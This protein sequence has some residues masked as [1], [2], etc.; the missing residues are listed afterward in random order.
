[1]KKCDNDYDEGERHKGRGRRAGASE[2]DRQRLARACLFVCACA[3]LHA[4]QA[5][6]SDEVTVGPQA[7]AEGDGTAPLPAGAH[8]PVRNGFAEHLKPH[9]ALARR[10]GASTDARP[11][12]PIRAP[13]DEGQV[14]EIEM[15]VGESRVFPAPGVARIAVGNGSILTA[16][17]L[18]QKEVILF[19]NGPGT[20]SLFVWNV[21]GR[22]QRV[23]VNIVPGDTSRFAR[24][25]AAFLTAIPNAKASVVGANII[26]EGDDLSDNDLRKIEELAKRYPQIVNFTNRLGWEQ[27]VLMDVKVVEFPST[28]L[29]EIGLKW[30]ATGGAAVG[31]IWAPGRRGHSGPYQIDIH[32]GE[33]NAPPITNPDGSGGGVVL[34]SGL[35]VLS[36]INMGLN[37]QLNLLAQEGKAAVLA[38]PQLSARNGA[39]ANFLAGGE[40][41][42]TVYTINGPRVQFKEYGVKLDIEPRVDHRGVIRAQINTEVSSIDQSVSTASGPALLS[43]K[44]NTEFNVRDGETIVLAGLLQRDTGSDVDKVPLLG[45]LP[46]LGP[47]FRSKR[48][49]NRETELVVFVTPT[50]VSAQS[51][52]LQDRVQRVSD[53]L[54]ER[55]GPPPH[56]TEP[57]QPGA[58]YQQ[59]NTTPAPAVAQPP[60][61]AGVDAPAAGRLPVS[62]SAPV[63]PA[64]APT[65]ADA[66]VARP[67]AAASAA[68]LPGGSALRVVVDA[69]ALRAEPH[70]RAPALLQLGIGSTVLMGGALPHADG[71]AVWRHV[72]VGSVSGWVPST[73]V[74]PARGSL[75]I[76]AAPGGAARQDQAGRLAALPSGRASAPE[77]L[78]PAP[79]DV[80]AASRYRVTL[81]RLALRVAPDINA[82]VVVHL[83]AGDVIG[84]L[85][86]PPR[87][88]WVAVQLGD[89]GE[90]KRGWVPAQW[91]EPPTLNSPLEGQR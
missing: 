86:Q 54:E 42:Y 67:P 23:K 35:N 20:S 40:I 61:T 59:P 89:G 15:F 47:L 28:V 79:R 33:G 26:V 31:G 10:T 27:M 58:Q 51:A 77:S 72:L 38:E 44:A 13:D 68:P 69:M 29:R 64:T 50:V 2:V 75:T 83:S 16:A 70:S 63:Q 57:L 56:L 18:D 80:P 76:A 74:R 7:R 14:P 24:E 84:L 34:P 60:A 39:R 49:Q 91:L 82:H 1:M 6:E 32:T 46:I 30:N 55:M 52:G 71:T 62:F 37:A 3:G 8:R 41:P 73:A 53:R 19:A 21:D 4:A 48:F 9:S 25:I 17:A 85:P 78:P 88:H 87:G 12:T 22:Y 11:Y 65:P 45:D 36:A 66:P 90:Q 43:R 5:R 81:E